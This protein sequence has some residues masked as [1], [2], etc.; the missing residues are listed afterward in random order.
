[1][2]PVPSKGV[3]VLKM[4]E[5]RESQRNIAVKFGISKTLSISLV[6]MKDLRRH[7]TNYKPE[8]IFNMDESCLFYLALLSF[9][10][11]ADDNHHSEAASSQT[12]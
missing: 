1:M 5:K 6:P 12:K 4:A 10:L 9:K 11:K 7:L 8:N 3:L 2:S